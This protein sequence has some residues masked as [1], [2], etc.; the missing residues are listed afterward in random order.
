MLD[1]LHAKN[2]LRKILKFLSNSMPPRKILKKD[3]HFF[4]PP[5]STN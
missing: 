4:I 3:M 5:K 2:H 1:G